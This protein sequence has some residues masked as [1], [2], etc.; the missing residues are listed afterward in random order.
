MPIHNPYPPYQKNSIHTPT[1]PHL[2]L[3]LYQRSLNFITLPNHP[4]QKQHPQIT[5]FNL[6]NPQN[7]IQ[8]LSLTL[9]P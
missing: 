4:I 8:Q 7:I 1:P 3:I 2:T 5:N 9:N 6:K